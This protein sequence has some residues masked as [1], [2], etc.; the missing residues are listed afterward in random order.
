VLRLFKVLKSGH[1]K[2][3]TKRIPSEPESR[4]RIESGTSG[5]PSQFLINKPSDLVATVH[6]TRFKVQKLNS[7]Q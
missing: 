4:P 7:N 2:K 6:I 5:I 3:K 1:C